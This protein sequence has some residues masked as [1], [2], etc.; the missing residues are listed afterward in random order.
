[1][2]NLS[3]SYTGK[4]YSQAVKEKKIKR[5]FKKTT[6]SELEKNQRSGMWEGRWERAVSAPVGK[7]GM[8]WESG[9]T[10]LPGPLCTKSPNPFHM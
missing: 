1:M 9:T 4:K 2:H 5:N 6:M 3:L 8:G 10:A 7:D